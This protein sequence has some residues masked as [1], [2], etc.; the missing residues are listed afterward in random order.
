MEIAFYKYEAAGN[1]F[2][3][4]DDRGMAFPS[5]DQKLVERLCHRRFG[6]GADGLILLQNEA[7]ADFRMVYFNLDG[8][9]GSMCG[10]GGRAVTAFA[11]LLYPDRK[12]FR[13]LAWDGPHLAEVIGLKAE[14]TLEVRL[15]MRDAEA[16]QAMGNDWVIDTGSPHYIR[17][18]TG[19]K[20]LDVVRDGRGI[21]NSEPFS[22][23]GINVNFVEPDHSTGL[24]V[25][26]YER[27]VEDETYSCGTGVTAAAITANFANVIHGNTVKIHTPGGELQVSF[28]RQENKYSNIVLQG[29]A[30]LVFTG[31]VKI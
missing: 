28:E 14:D 8:K 27:G 6:V 21:R 26:T 15:G 10:N 3:I 13:F 30:R 7:L 4:I 12:H 5:D 20:V 18:C 23:K 31:S 16:P 1:D 9:E 19:L 29:P 25:R 22:E 24:N 17:F 11:H 2:L